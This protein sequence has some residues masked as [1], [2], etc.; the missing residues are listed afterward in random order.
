[1][2]WKFFTTILPL[3]H[4]AISVFLDLGPQNWLFSSVAIW[5]DQGL[6]CHDQVSSGKFWEFFNLWCHLYMFLDITE[7]RA[8]NK[9]S[10]LDMIGSDL[11][12]NA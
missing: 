3:W 12:K 6:F 7:P 8:E 10:S 11:W 9:N 5:V 4:S 2:E 1:M